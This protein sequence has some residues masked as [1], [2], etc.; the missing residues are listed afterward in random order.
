MTRPFNSLAIATTRRL[1]KPSQRV[2]TQTQRKRSRRCA[3]NQKTVGTTRRSTSG[4]IN[5]KALV[6]RHR[7]V[8]AVDGRHPLHADILLTPRTKKPSGNNRTD[9][10]RVIDPE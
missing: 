5:S 7:H 2:A 8:L 4:S 3:G 1:L 9:L 6:T 10:E